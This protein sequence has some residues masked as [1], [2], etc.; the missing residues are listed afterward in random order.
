MKNFVAGLGSGSHMSCRGCPPGDFC[1]VCGACQIHG[2]HNGALH[3]P[4]QRLSERRTW[5]QQ[6]AVA[7]PSRKESAELVKDANRRTKPRWWQKP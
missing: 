7:R 5:S 3:I 6:K 1:S 2:R 4:A